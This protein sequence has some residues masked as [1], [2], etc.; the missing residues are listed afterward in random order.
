MNNDPI[1]IDK[2]PHIDWILFKSGVKLLTAGVV[3]DD[4][5]GRFPSDHY[6]V[7]AIFYHKISETG[8][9]NIS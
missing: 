1:T 3:T 6:P 8:R 7:R 2:A 9:E 5:S 4:F